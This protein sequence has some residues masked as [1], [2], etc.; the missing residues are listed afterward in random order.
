MTSGQ[1]RRALRR[2]FGF[3]EFREH[4]E[5][6]VQAIVAGRDVFAALPTGGGKSLCYQLPATLIDG[7][8]VVV[9]PL[10]ALMQDQVDG[11]V[12]DGVRAAYLN[13]SMD[14]EAIRRTWLDLSG[15]TVDLLYVSP[16][17]LSNPDFRSHLR[18]WNLTGIAVDEAHCISEWGHEFRQEYRN[19][20]ILRDEYPQ[21]PIAAFTATA[22]GEV[23]R[24]VV[25]Q[26][27]LNDP[28]IVRAGFDRPEI[29][30]RVEPRRHETR[31]IV[32]FVTA[33]SGSAGI[34]YRST[35]NAVEQTA[36][37]LVEAGIPA[38]PYHAGL[39]AET[40][41]RRQ[42]EFVNDEVDVV[43]AT[44]AFGMGID[45]SNVRWIVHGDLPR[46]LEA[47]YQE[48]GRAGRDGEQAEALLLHGA[49]DL[50]TIR[51]H[52]GNM[53]RERERERA[54]RNVREV[55]SYVESG[56]CRRQRL[57]AHF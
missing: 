33:R 22:T 29:S 4:Q 39:D 28:L 37:R 23:Q 9:S 25:E 41:R 40:R 12:Q 55:L 18:E 27:S 19:L 49:K 11:A 10:I 32:E 56:A 13:S 15:G 21:V 42:R 31:Q 20:A 43:V 52:I 36:E 5:Q 35:R 38:V 14:A 34:V 45:K 6:I 8:T 53:E 50:S 16:E 26:L 57:L 24:D 51:W 30:Y 54:E 46:S 17:R 7:L 48:T 3:D 2:Q 47:Y 44:I 1:L